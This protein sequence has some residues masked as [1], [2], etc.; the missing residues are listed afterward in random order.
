MKA[1]CQLNKSIKNFAAD[2]ELNEKME[3]R[4]IVLC[5]TPTQKGSKGLKVKISQFRSS[6][7]ASAWIICVEKSE[8]S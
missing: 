5:K 8:S 7:W 4:I 3:V 6:S 1:D 2:T